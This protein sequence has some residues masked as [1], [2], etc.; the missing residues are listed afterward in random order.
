MSEE[1]SNYE[2]S[3]YFKMGKMLTAVDK[4]ERDNAV[5][6][7][8]KYVFKGNTDSVCNGFKINVLF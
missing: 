3:S 5:H 7:I 1:L 6:I 2:D 8:K 4:E